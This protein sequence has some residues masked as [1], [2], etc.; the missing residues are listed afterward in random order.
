MLSEI[1]GKKNGQ[2]ENNYQL[3]LLSES[4]FKIFEHLIPGEARNPLQSSQ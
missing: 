1:D 4:Y 2:E 3:S